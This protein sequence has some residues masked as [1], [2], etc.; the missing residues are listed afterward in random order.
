M[1]KMDTIERVKALLMSYTKLRAA[2]INSCNFSGLA[3]IL[4]DLDRFVSYCEFTNRQANIIDLYYH[5]GF[6]QTE[7]AEALNITQQGI[8]FHLN[9]IDRKIEKS[10]KKLP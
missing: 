10:I 2:M 5:K 7:V 4:L 8:S 1:Y 9:N 3:D 6:T